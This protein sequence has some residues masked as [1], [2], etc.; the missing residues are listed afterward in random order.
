[1]P[2]TLFTNVWIFDGSGSPRFPGEVLVEGNHI[3]RVG[4]TAPGASAISCDGAARI[5]GG[6][7]TLMPGLV[8][9]HAHLSFASSR[10]RIIRERVLPPEENLLITA[11]NARVYLDHGFTSA[12][13][14]GS[15][16][17]RFEVAL[18]KEI[19]GGYL[20]GPRLIPSTFERPANADKERTGPEA[21]K[22]FVAD[23]AQDGVKSIKLLLSGDDAFGPGGSQTVEYTEADVAAAAAQARE[24]NVWLVAHAQAAAAVKMAARNGFRVIYHCTY[25]DEEALDL[26]EA[27]KDDIFLGP[28][29]GIIYAKAYLGEAFGFTADKPNHAGF[30]DAIE[31]NVAIYAELRKRGVRVLPGGD[32]G[33]PWNPIGENARDME[34]FVKLFGWKPEE[35]L[36]AGTKWG[37]ELMDLGH[38]LGQVREGFLADLLLVRDDPV[39]HIDRLRDAGNLLA[40]MQNGRFHKA[41]HAASNISH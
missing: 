32:Y 4:R 21:L 13:S 12:Y 8:E 31:R 20:P 9:S 14:A 1:V 40:I 29:I 7:A 16:G 17:P 39:A 6:G 18:K 23:M 22:K 38:Q 36:M 41:P 15:K 34:L 27:R 25:A 11:Y 10:K 3:T 24:S 19:D 35:A 5:D 26:I 30:L 33:F 2:A 37:A 28:A